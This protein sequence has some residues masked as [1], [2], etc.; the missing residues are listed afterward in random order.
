VKLDIEMP[1]SL[2]GLKYESCAI[3]NFVDILTYT[4]ILLDLLLLYPPG[5]VVNDLIQC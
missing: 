1:H 2:F 4:F 5:K 3:I